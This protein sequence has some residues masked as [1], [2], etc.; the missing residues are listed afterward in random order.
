MTGEERF[1]L[2]HVTLRGNPPDGKTAAVEVDVR[3]LFRRDEPADNS[4]ITIRRLRFGA[5]LSHAKA[6]QSCVYAVPGTDMPPQL[7]LTRVGRGDYFLKLADDPSAPFFEIRVPAGR[8]Q[9]VRRG[10]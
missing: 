3:Q 2:A 4:H 7:R 9:E 10:A 5:T 8:V 6:I 1:I